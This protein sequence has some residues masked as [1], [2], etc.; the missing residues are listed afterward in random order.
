MSVLKLPDGTCVEVTFPKKVLDLLQVDEHEVLAAIS[1]GNGPMRLAKADSKGLGGFDNRAVSEL[2]RSV[3]KEG[4]TPYVAI[5]T[6]KVAVL[7][8]DFDVSRYN[9]LLFCHM[10][11]SDGSSQLFSYWR[12]KNAFTDHSD[13]FV[14]EYTTGNLVAS[15]GAFADF[16]PKKKRWF[17]KSEFWT[18]VHNR[19]TPVGRSDRGFGDAFSKKIRATPCRQR[20]GV[21]CSESEN[22][23]DPSVKGG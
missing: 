19:A 4:G 21:I 7:P 2:L 3:V 9:G 13:S 5:H 14:S 20:C 1:S 11:R 12:S 10:V 22:G 18:P 23:R 16:Y 6:P 17:L 8:V 15:S